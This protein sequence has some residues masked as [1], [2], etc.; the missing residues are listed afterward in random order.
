M[1]MDV[2]SIEMFVLRL[3]VIKVLIRLNAKTLN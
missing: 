3:G 2:R 1:I